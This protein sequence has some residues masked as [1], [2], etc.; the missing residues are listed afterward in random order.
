MK[1]R[2]MDDFREWSMEGKPSLVGVLEVIFTIEE[3]SLRT[4]EEKRNP[5]G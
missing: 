4:K 2:R 5:K 3:A 1:G